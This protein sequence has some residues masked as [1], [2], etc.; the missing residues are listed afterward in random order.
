[1]LSRKR[2]EKEQLQRFEV[3][4]RDSWNS[5]SMFGREE[6]HE[7]M[8]EKNSKKRQEQEAA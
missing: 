7:R 5:V 8:E 1:M 6:K 3:E 2:Q 4:L